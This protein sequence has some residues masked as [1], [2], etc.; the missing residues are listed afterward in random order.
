VHQP[1]VQLS[2]SAFKGALPDLS[3]LSVHRMDTDGKA[4]N[5]IWLREKALWKI[6]RISEPLQYFLRGVTQSI[7]HLGEMALSNIC[8]PS[9]GNLT[10]PPRLP[11][12]YEQ[13]VIES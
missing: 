3:F 4:I 10:Q 1:D 5:S 9:K 13:V 11:P 2:M 8:A 7:F 6:E 12:D